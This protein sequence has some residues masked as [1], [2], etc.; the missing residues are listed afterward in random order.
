MEIAVQQLL[1]A[2][3]SYLNGLGLRRLE[4][5]VIELSVTFLRNYSLFLI[6]FK[7]IK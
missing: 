3:H 4:D 1:S 5:Y 7:A 6:T 2:V